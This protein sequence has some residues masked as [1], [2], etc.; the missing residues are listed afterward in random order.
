M[1]FSKIAATTLSDDIISGKTALGAEP[2]DTDEF[3][4]S[5]AGT[6]KRVDYSYIKGGGGLVYINGSESSSSA[7]AVTFDSVFS[8]TYRAYRIIGMIAP[9]TDTWIKFRLRASSSDKNSNEYINLERTSYIDSGESQA[10]NNYGNHTA[11]YGAFAQADIDSDS[12]AHYVAFD[13]T[14]YDPNTDVFGRHMIN[15]TYSFKN[16]GSDKLYVGN[17]ANSATANQNADGI[18]FETNA[19]TLS[20]HSIRVYGIVN[21]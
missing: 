8:S 3:I 10:Q 21:S 2:A 6:L 7:A 12:N 11:T 18:K 4:V 1:A 20:Y 19:G 16:G 15:G 9:S 13:F 14:V 17:F 5:D